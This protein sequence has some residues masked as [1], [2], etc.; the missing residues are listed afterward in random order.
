MVDKNIHLRYLSMFQNEFR[1]NTFKFKLF[2]SKTSFPIVMFC[3]SVFRR[4]GVNPVIKK[5]NVPIVFKKRSSSED[6]VRPAPS[7]MLP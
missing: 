5:R 6:K 4:Q 7:D 2:T 1:V 3:S